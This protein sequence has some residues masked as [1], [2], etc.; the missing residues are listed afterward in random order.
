[1]SESKYKSRRFQI[2]VFGCVTVTV[3]LFTG[4]VDGNVWVA[5]FGVSAG[6]FTM[7]DTYE[8]KNRTDL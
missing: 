6:I 2:A 8:K 4:F 3:A 5:G 7:A 1:L